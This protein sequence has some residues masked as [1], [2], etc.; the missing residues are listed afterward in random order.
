M[1]LETVEKK[2]HI[3]YPQACRSIYESGAMRWMCG[4]PQAQ[5]HFFPNQLLETMCPEYCRG[6]SPL[7]FSDVVLVRENLMEQV[8]EHGGQWKEGVQILPFAW[9]DDGD[10]YFFDAA[11]E[12]PEAPVFAWMK[13]SGEIGL[14]NRSFEHF[15]FSHLCEPILYADLP[16]D[17]WWVR[18]QQGWLTPEHQA[19]LASGDSEALEELFSQLYIWEETD[20]LIYQ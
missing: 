12:D 2:L 6:W 16:A 9:D 1:K 3:A 10:I 11:L 4:R 13:F 5:S 14:T 15:I 8:Q 7:L 20:Y 19:V 17:H 18:K